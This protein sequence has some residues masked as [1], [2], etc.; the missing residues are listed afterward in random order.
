MPK[1]WLWLCGIDWTLIAWTLWESVIV[2][3]DFYLPKSCK[4]MF[5][6]R[7]CWNHH[8]TQAQKLTNVLQS[9]IGVSEPYLIWSWIIVNYIIMGYILGL[10]FS[11]LREAMYAFKGSIFLPRA[12]HSRQQRSAYF[13]NKSALFPRP[14]IRTAFSCIKCPPLIFTVITK[15]K[16]SK[17]FSHSRV[18][19]PSHQAENINVVSDLTALIN[20]T[21]DR[22]MLPDQ[23][24][25][26][27]IWANQHSLCQYSINLENIFSPQDEK[28]KDWRIVGRQGKIPH[29]AIFVLH[30]ERFK[31]TCRHMGTLSRREISWK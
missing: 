22:Q 9:S 29:D 11:C 7:F 10:N 19:F 17:C 6:T 13:W 15:S 23:N 2:F 21:W 16:I 24:L 1:I 3:W 8:Y 27:D 31:I 12:C 18:C 25:Y 5:I 28:K 14:H 26:I 4:A 30:S 20:M